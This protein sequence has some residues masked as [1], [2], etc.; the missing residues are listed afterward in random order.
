M[1]Q[2][3]SPLSGTLPVDAS[4]EAACGRSA[5]SEN[6]SA[7]D[8]NSDNQE[9]EKISAEFAH[10]LDC[11]PVP[12]FILNLE[13]CISH[14]NKACEHVLGFSSEFMLGTKNQWMPFYRAQRPVLADMILHKKVDSDIY[15]LFGGKVKP[16]FLANGACE[17][18]AFYENL[19]ENGLWLHFTATPLLNRKG[20][21][22]GAIQTLEDI[23]EQK[24]AEAALRLAH[25]DL[26]LLVKKR[27]AQ[28][29]EA[30]R[31][32][33]LDIRE[34]EAIESELIRR[35][36]DL[37]EL[38]SKLYA[39]QEQLI[40][41][42]KLASIGQL[43]AGVAHEINNPIGYIFSNFSSLEKYIAQ[44][45]E[46]IAA[47]EQ[48]EQHITASAAV[49]VI[50]SLKDTIELEFLKQDIP[51]LMAQSKE[52]IGRVRKIVQDLKDFSRTD[53]NQE[54]QWSNLHDGINSTLNI[55]AGE[56]KYRADVIKEYG[57]IP[58]IECLSSQ[59]NQVLMNLIVNAAHA[60]DGER[61][62]ITI[63]TSSD[64]NFVY[65]SVADNGSGIATENISKIFDP[66][67]T[68]KPVGKGTG[69]GLSLSYG[70]IKR[71]HG[72][73]TVESEPGKGTKFSIM[74]PI[75]HDYTEAN[76]EASPDAH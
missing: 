66:F 73:I 76:L 50:E 33:E 68:T 9:L 31:L 51:D 55:V 74:L 67:F 37:T 2:D 36:N 28:L 56:I 53:S 61:G 6:Q 41:S 75:C 54:W 22:I 4:Q 47:Y 1:N 30:N 29:A 10:F 69:L 25:S 65:I 12:T 58:A 35:N 59:I 11:S 52:G 8:K 5:A 19:G 45:F 20:A 3:F 57:D 21:L 60:I 39:A 70:I 23:T 38:N 34:R 40:Q 15:G 13:H 32:L 48:I 49:G 24:E 27:T 43:A 26:E 71:H 17:V 64:K 62:T 18:D 7:T 72:Q 16:S 14:W 44:L 63:K 46:M 42:E